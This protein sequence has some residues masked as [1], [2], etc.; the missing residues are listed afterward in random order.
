M[1]GTP[2]TVVA[3]DFG[4]RRIGIAV[5]QQ[6]THSASPVGVAANGEA[7][8]DWAT[9][10]AIITDWNPAR[11]IVGLPLNAD[12]T[13]SE[14]GKA[15]RRFAAA[16]ARFDRPVEMIDERH[17]SAEAR[18]MLRKER[19]L[20]IRG[21]IRRQTIDA[22]AATLIAERWLTQNSQSTTHETE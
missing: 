6:V 17:T 2:E 16:L 20:G 8:P 4:L 19:A 21:R 10:D 11:L 15:V 13:P 12:G 7:G 1:P 18:D 9:I 22:A 14:I 5:G 3:F